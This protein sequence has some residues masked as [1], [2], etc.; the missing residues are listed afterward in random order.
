MRQIW[1]AGR[2]TSAASTFFDPIKIGPNLEEFVDGATGCNN[3]V[4]ELWTEAMDMWPQETLESN[5]KC[6]VSIG[7]GQPSLKPFGENIIDIGKTLLDLATDT[8][9]T[10]EL[11]LREHRGLALR[12]CYFRFNVERGLEAVGLEDFQQKNVI[13]AATRKYITS[14]AIFEHIQL[15][16]ENLS[17]RECAPLFP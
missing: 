9:R 17:T 1:E 6:L 14:Q 16:A 11:F 12:K 5:V 15:C 13:A 10:A 2:A 4:R 7:T 8:E 3:P